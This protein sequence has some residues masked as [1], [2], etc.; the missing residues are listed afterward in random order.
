MKH[1]SDLLI[2]GS[3]IAGLTFALKVAEW[4]TVN[5]VTKKEGW[6]SNTNY[7]QGG[8]AS[9]LADDDSFERHV[10][11]TIR[12]GDGL[13]HEEV[14]RQVVEEAPAR[15]RELIGWGVEFDRD[16]DNRLALGREGGHSRDRIVHIK[17]LT[18]YE[19]ERA[20]LARVQA[21][22]NIRLY[23]DHTAVDLITE[24]HLNRDGS[25]DLHCY[26]TYVLQN[27]TGEV[28]RFQARLTM[29]ATGGA[30]QVYLHTTNPGIATGDGI[31]MAYRAGACL[32]NLEFMQFHPT[33]L[34]H[35]LGESFLITEALR[36]EGAVLRNLQGEEFI[37]H[38][39]GSLAPRDIVA[40]AIDG[41][42]KRTGVSHL[43]LDATA[44]SA[45]QL[46]ER[47]PQIHRQCQRFGIDITSTPIPVVP[48]AHY[49]CGG[50]VID[51][52]GR[53]SVPG[54]FACG[55]VAH[56]GLHGANRLASNALLEALVLAHNAA[57]VAPD[58]LVTMNKVVDR[59]PAW[60][61][62]GTYDSEE[63][64]LIQH[65]LQELQSLMWD[66]VGIVRSRLRLE[67]AQR[68]VNTLGMEIHD[69]Y[70][71]TSVTTPLLE[72]RNLAATAHLIIKAALERNE[73]R[74][75]HYRRDFPERN[76]ADWLHDT[77]S[78]S[79]GDSTLT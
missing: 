37:D 62:S 45:R 9:V 39:Q 71:K 68:R 35:P 56:T 1:E 48:A 40:R 25:G 65:N 78:Q 74:G 20:L 33:T 61:A 67:R 59:I 23:T 38:P 26:G 14:V 76:D 49:L 28:H 54:L 50:V 42:M 27:D 10:R 15:I 77:I 41:E 2:I 21:H 13:C 70:R 16:N 57:L 18:G 52:N 46:I 69:F 19:V 51:I 79:G 72:L 34:Y 43:H 22:P 44:I 60:D 30:G 55:E 12:A 6:E 32:S 8:I 63:W 11:D 5:I 58:S 64:V 47:F 17:D 66:Y 4:G 31:A 7:A 3:G 53:T 29:L 75:L 36:G 24:H 73:S